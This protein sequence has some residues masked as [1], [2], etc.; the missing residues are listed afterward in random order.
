MVIKPCNQKDRN[1]NFE[2]CANRYSK[3]AQHCHT[4]KDVAAMVEYLAIFI[5]NEIPCVA[6]R[7]LANCF[8]LLLWVTT[9]PD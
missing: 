1:Q 6:L 7:I 8:V 3:P 2:G 4:F 9:P 5:S